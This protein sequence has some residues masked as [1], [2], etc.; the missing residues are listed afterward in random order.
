MDMFEVQEDPYLRYG[1]YPGQI[2]DSNGQ[3]NPQE[4]S[5]A[6][7][8]GYLP[9][10]RTTPQTPYDRARDVTGILELRSAPVQVLDSAELVDQHPFLHVTATITADDCDPRK[11]GTRDPMLSGP[12]RPD[13]VLLSLFEYRGAGTSNTKY[14]DVPDGRVFSPYGSQDGSTWLP[15]QDASIAVAALDTRNSPAHADPSRNRTAQ[16]TG[17]RLPPGPSHGWTSV[18]VVNVKAADNLKSTKLLRQQ[19]SPHQDRKANSTVAGQTYG[20]RTASVRNTRPV[21][22]AVSSEEMWW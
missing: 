2:T 1:S 17:K 15:Y 8:T 19:Q 22:P 20:Q 13:T 5:K 11:T 12:A 18:P 16:P 4:I 6:A 7:P 14:K 9:D 10:A 3:R 21:G